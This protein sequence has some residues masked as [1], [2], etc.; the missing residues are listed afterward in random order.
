MRRI[1]KRFKKIFLIA[2]FFLF[3]SGMLLQPVNAQ[4][5]EFSDAAMFAEV[6]N[7]NLAYAHYYGEFALYYDSY[8]YYGWADYF[9]NLALSY[10][11]YA[12]DYAYWAQDYALNGYIVWANLGSSGPFDWPAYYYAWYAWRYTSFAWDSLYSYNTPGTIDN[13]YWANYFN[14]AAIYNSALASDGGLN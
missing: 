4:N 14:G 11:G 5:F 8:G 10:T 2:G 3:L 7:E 12:E 13:G 9:N 1:S 6:S